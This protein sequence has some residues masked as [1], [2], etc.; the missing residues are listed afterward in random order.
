MS[1]PSNPPKTVKNKHIN[2]Y[3]SYVRYSHDFSSITM[4]SDDQDAIMYL[5]YI[6]S[7]SRDVLFTA[8]LSRADVTG[9]AFRA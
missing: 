5:T 4:I 1:D 8:T 2:M 9:V 7:S 3:T 6:A